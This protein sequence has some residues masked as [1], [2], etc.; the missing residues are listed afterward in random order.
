MTLTTSKVCRILR[1]TRTSNHKA[2]RQGNVKLDFEQVTL[3][4]QEELVVEPLIWEMVSV[5]VFSY[6]TIEGSPRP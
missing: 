4:A 3:S 2:K 6:P 1:G 5:Y